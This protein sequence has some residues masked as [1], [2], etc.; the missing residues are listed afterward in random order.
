MKKIEIKVKTPPLC[1]VCGDKK[2]VPRMFIEKELGMIA[3]KQLVPCPR[4][5][6]KKK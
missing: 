5:R 3:G 2:S 4:C 1:H 6:G